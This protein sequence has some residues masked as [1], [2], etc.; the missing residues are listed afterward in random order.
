M[1]DQDEYEEE[2]GP[3]KSAGAAHPASQAEESG[4]GASGSV[5]GHGA[6]ARD[7]AEDY[8]VEEEF[9]A[10][11]DPGG[12]IDLSLISPGVVDSMSVSMGQGDRLAADASSELSTAVK[13]SEPDDAPAPSNT[14]KPLLLPSRSFSVPSV[15]SVPLATAVDASQR[16]ASVP[17]VPA[18]ALKRWTDGYEHVSDGE[19]SPRSKHT[20]VPLPVL[21]ET[22][23]VC[24]DEEEEVGDSGSDSDDSDESSQSGGESPSQTVARLRSLSLQQRNQQ[25]VVLPARKS[26]SQM[27]LTRLPSVSEMAAEDVARMGLPTTL[28]AY[29]DASTC[30]IAS[31]HEGSPPF[32]QEEG[33]ASPGL[34]E[35]A[36]ERD[37]ATKST[38]S[39]EVSPETN[40]TGSQVHGVVSPSITADTSSDMP[41]RR[42]TE[43]L[44]WEVQT[45][46]SAQRADQAR[47]TS[48]DSDRSAAIFPTVS[49]DDAQF[50][51]ERGESPTGYGDEEFSD[52][53][54]AGDNEDVDK[55][56]D[57][58]DAFSDDTREQLGGA[59]GPRDPLST[60]GS[61]TNAQI[62]SIAG[63][64]DDSRRETE[65][66][67]REA[68]ALI[69]AQREVLG[70]KEDA[71]GI[72][73]VLQSSTF[74]PYGKENDFDE[75]EAASFGDDDPYL[76]DDDPV[77]SVTEEYRAVDIRLE[78]TVDSTVKGGEGGLP[79]STHSSE[80]HFQAQDKNGEGATDKPN[81]DTP[82]DLNCDGIGVEESDRHGQNRASAVDIQKD[83]R[84]S[85]DAQEKSTRAVEPS[86]ASSQ[87]K[88]PRPPPAKTKMDST[89]GRRATSNTPT[90]SRPMPPF[91]A[92][93]SCGRVNRTS[94]TG[95]LIRPTIAS[96]GGVVIETQSATHT[97]AATDV[98]MP[99]E[100]DDSTLASTAATPRSEQAPS[101]DRSTRCSPPKRTQQLQLPDEYPSLPRKEPVPRQKKITKKPLSPELLRELK[102]VKSPPNLRIDAQIVDKD[103]RDW[104]FLNMFRHG[105]DVSKYE[106]FIPRSVLPPSKGDSIARPPSA[107]SAAPS[108][109]RAERARSSTPYGFGGRKLIKPQDPMLIERE[110][111]WV[112]TKPLDSAIP[113]YD[114]ILDKYCATVTSPLIQRHIYHTRYEDLS[115]Q[116]AFVLE[117]R[118]EQHFKQVVRAA[119]SPASCYHADS[120][121]Q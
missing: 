60:S 8:D 91:Q 107:S 113:A 47:A 5:S 106:S 15:P 2:E 53:G 51:C 3:P 40:G 45:L 28:A 43:Q 57:D 18:A 81:T 98:S 76:T 52:E 75:D 83:N 82:Q 34:R 31:T 20:L 86:T 39:D 88:R 70:T 85:A 12:S 23:P 63:L 121:G 100:A 95:A 25:P 119:K 1:Y 35:S 27:F 74:D 67:L 115:P 32:R 38:V 72:A 97:T 112:A 61:E 77:D 19:G 118:V 116:L 22:R 21:E 58:E 89:S 11:D 36:A 59:D 68:Q 17:S 73:T 33:Q 16:S 29:L 99:Q 87:S 80:E 42:E 84:S 103:K 117:K 54:E 14:R 96:R 105:D 114:S 90:T 24:L 79:K 108:L 49:E 13:A 66:L 30:S 41:N 9:E 110:K 111:N 37:A 71:V 64:E 6:D 109:A 69:Q 65:A 78:N 62:F 50:A 93:S 10:E 55:Y 7:E 104:L 92:S 26:K 102:P 56:A 48:T 4:A 44:V 101:P 120:T 46:I 94:R